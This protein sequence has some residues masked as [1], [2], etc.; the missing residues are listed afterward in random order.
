[1]GLAEPEVGPPIGLAESEHIPG[2][3]VVLLVAHCRT[4]LDH[5]HWNAV[6]P[7]LEVLHS[8]AAFDQVV[9]RFGAQVSD[10]APA[11]R[12]AQ[13]VSRHPAA[14][15]A[16]SEEDRRLILVPACGRGQ[17]GRVPT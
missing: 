14:L 9:E 2:C 6:D 4:A 1:M 11:V 7:G 15:R 17:D 3:K 12:A 10:A 16:A 5:A 8:L 13:V